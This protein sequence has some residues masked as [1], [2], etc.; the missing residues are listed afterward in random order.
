MT[1]VR[2]PSRVLSDGTILAAVLGALLTSLGTYFAVRRAE[3]ERGRREE[4]REIDEIVAH[5]W[6]ELAALRGQLDRRSSIGTTLTQDYESGRLRVREIGREIARLSAASPGTVHQEWSWLP[7]AISELTVAQFLN[8]IPELVEAELATMDRVIAAI[9]DRLPTVHPAP[10]PKE[11]MA[12]AEGRGRALEAAARRQESAGYD[13]LLEGAGDRSAASSAIA[14]A[15]AYGRLDT[16]L[17][18]LEID[19]EAELAPHTM[20]PLATA[21]LDHSDRLVAQE[22]LDRLVRVLTTAIRHA[23]P[24]KPGEWVREVVGETSAVAGV[25]GLTQLGDTDALGPEVQ[26]ALTERLKSHAARWAQHTQALVD[27]QQS[28]LALR[29]WVEDD[30]EQ[31]REWATRNLNHGNS[32]ARASVLMCFCSR[33]AADGDHVFDLDLAARV[34]DVGTLVR[35]AEYLEVGG[36]ALELKPALAAFRRA[37]AEPDPEE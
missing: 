5:C 13:A 26:E 30:L 7:T 36:V 3:D 20:R 19:I 23:N 12:A 10:V 15:I 4:K 24:D 17:Q 22:T 33:P 1:S 29:W 25:V 34:V 35:A 11:V 16:Y 31:M 27:C 2:V 9:E 37:L 8:G 6:H 32:W 18:R 14:E 28:V 21:L